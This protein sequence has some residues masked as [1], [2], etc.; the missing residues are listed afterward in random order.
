MISV[1]DV[2]KRNLNHIPFLGLTIEEVYKSIDN[3]YT[4]TLLSLR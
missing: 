2:G 3:K 4:F 1:F